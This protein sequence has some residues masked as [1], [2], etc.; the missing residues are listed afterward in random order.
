MKCAGK[1]VLFQNSS[2]LSRQ[3][4]DSIPKSIQFLFDSTLR[5]ASYL[6]VQFENKF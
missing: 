2:C 3:S 6:T 1:N 5:N 4:D